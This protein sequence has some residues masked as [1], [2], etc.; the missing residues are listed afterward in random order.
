MNY[1][2]RIL[3]GI[4]FKEYQEFLYK[5]WLEKQGRKPK[6]FI[7]ILNGLTNDLKKIGVLKHDEHLFLINHVSVLT[8]LLNQYLAHEP[9]KAKNERGNNYYSAPFKKYIK[10]HEPR[11]K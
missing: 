10:F 1:P 2:D 7:A 6:K 3:Q 4:R 9:Y 5:T 11:T 8:N